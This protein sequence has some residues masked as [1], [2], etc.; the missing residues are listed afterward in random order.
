MV[1]FENNI[2]SQNIDGHPIQMCINDETKDPLKIAIMDLSYKENRDKHVRTIIVIFICYMC[3]ISV[4]SSRTPVHSIFILI[5]LVKL[6][7]LRNLVESGR[8]Y[9]KWSFSFEML[10]YSHF[11]VFFF[12]LSEEVIFIKNFCIQNTTSYSFGRKKVKFVSI[13]NVHDIV[14]N[15]VIY[16]VSY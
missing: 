12:S 16:G 4:L 14:I 13:S 8:I 7:L 1:K 6:Y 15:E 3:V 9:S 2:V 5:L 10:E 11:D